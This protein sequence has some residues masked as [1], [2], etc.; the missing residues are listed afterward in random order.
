MSG[1][2]KAMTAQGRVASNLRNNIL[3]RAVVSVWRSPRRMGTRVA[4][5]VLAHRRAAAST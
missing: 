1:A 4:I 2:A 5:G 3:V